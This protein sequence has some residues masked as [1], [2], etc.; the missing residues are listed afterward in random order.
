MFDQF[1]SQYPRRC[2]KKAARKA[3]DKLTPAQQQCAL[4]ALPRW[5]IVWEKTEMH[6]IPHPAT[7]LNGE[8]FEDELPPM[9]ATKKDARTAVM[10]NVMNPPN[11]FQEMSNEPSRPALAL[12]RR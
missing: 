6:F 11:R 7:W 2:A 8:R 5:G 9:Q 1:W 12:V 3:W 10:S 4:D